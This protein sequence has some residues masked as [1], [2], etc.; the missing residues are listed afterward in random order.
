LWFTEYNNNSIGRLTTTSNYS[1]YP[2]PSTGPPADNYSQDPYYLTVGGDGN[3]WFTEWAGGNVSRLIP[4][5]GVITE[6]L[7][8]YGSPSCIATGPDKNIWFGDYSNNSLNEFLLPTLGITLSNS[9][10]VLTWPAGA[11]DYTLQGN[12]NLTGTN[13]V[14]LTSPPP[15]IVSNLFVYTNTVTNLAFFRLVLT[16]IP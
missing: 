13:W 1:V 3:I 2:L 14:N 9:Q 7:D 4:S 12:T 5:S 6:F 8:P 16:T 10:F 11:T 15:V